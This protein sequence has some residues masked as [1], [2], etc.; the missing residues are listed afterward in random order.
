[1]SKKAISIYMAATCA[2]GVI[3]PGRFVCGFI[4]AFEI[5]LLMLSGDLF[6]SLLSLLKIEKLNQV[7]LLLFVVYVTVMIKELLKFIMPMIALQMGFLF[8]LPAISTF[9]TVFLLEENN[10]SLV[11]NLK[12]NT[13]ASLLFAGYILL[14]TLIRDIFG[15]GTLSLP[16][17]G[18]PFELIIFNPESVSAMTF[19]ATIP[20]SLV[21][22]A[23]ILAL[24]LF[25]E[26]K[27]HILQK[28]GF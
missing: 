13:P 25:I 15:Y 12:S 4:V 14:I 8:Y 26:N 1:M 11:E 10:N 22:T 2:I 21:L 18:A 17:V 5:V 27:I 3:C 19:L 24:F 16:K 20:G 7:L 28:V 23:L 6:R 9:T